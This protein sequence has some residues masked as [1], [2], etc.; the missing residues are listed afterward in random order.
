MNNSKISNSQKNNS[1]YSENGTFGKNLVNYLDKHK[2]L[3]NKK[4]FK[5]ATNIKKQDIN[6]LLN[7]INDN[8]C[9]N[10]QEILFFDENIATHNDNT[11]II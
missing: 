5:H 11:I 1:I 7:M 3:L 2:I 10:N 4:K 6:D 8:K 9:K